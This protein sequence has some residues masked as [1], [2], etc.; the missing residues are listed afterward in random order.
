[1]WN[2]SCDNESCALHMTRNG[3]YLYGDLSIRR[4]LVQSMHSSGYMRFVSF[5][6]FV[7]FFFLY[8]RFQLLCVSAREEEMLRAGLAHRMAD[9]FSYRS[10]KKTGADF[11][12]FPVAGLIFGTVP[13]MV[14]LVWQF[15]SLRLVYKVTAKPQR[16]PLVFP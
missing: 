4:S 11:I 1:M 9:A 16:G 3:Q 7:Y 13:A 12:L 8:E 5:L 6:E 14:A 10:W 15:W 2:E